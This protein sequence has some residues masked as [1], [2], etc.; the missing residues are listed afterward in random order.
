MSDLF[1]RVQVALIEQG[2][3]ESLEEIY[4]G[5]FKKV[6]QELVQKEENLSKIDN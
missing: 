4:T 1:G 2:T 6:K 3:S 5:S